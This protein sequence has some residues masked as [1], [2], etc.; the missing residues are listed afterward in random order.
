MLSPIERYT[1]RDTEEEE[2]Q[3][4]IPPATWPATALVP[5]L[6][7][8]LPSAATSD[9][10][11][12]YTSARS[13][14]LGGGGSVDSTGTAF[15][16]ESSLTL[17][18]RSKLPKIKTTST[19]S[20]PSND[21]QTPTS[22]S[23]Q[24]ESDT[25]TSAA[26]CAAAQQ[27]QHLEDTRTAQL[28]TL[29]EQADLRALE[30]AMVAEPAQEQGVVVPGGSVGSAFSNASRGVPFTTTPRMGEPISD[31]SGG[32]HRSPLRRVE[33]PPDPRRALM[34]ERRAAEWRRLTVPERDAIIVINA[35]C[36]V[37]ERGKGKE[38]GVCFNLSFNGV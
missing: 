16:G 22:M 21:Q 18:H 33:T 15:G 29:A 31:R 4:H 38:K 9:T 1:P 27:Q 23:H 37:R 32:G 17:E 13:A 2:E 24:S 3:D 26:A 10:V 8:N 5:P 30:K 28:A 20:S 7:L 11:S 12:P 35:M 14:G 19:N 25:S 36:K 34:K 6:N